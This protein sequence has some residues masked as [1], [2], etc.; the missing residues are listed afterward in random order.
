MGRT[1]FGSFSGWKEGEFWEMIVSFPCFTYS[2]RENRSATITCCHFC[3]APGGQVLGAEALL[4]LGD[5]TMRVWCWWVFMAA[6]VVPYRRNWCG[7]CL[8]TL[9]CQGH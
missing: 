3:R 9:I 5:G 1:K 4:A 7:E 2:S 6:L 8:E